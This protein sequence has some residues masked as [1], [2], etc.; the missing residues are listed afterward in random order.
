M[1]YVQLTIRMA[2]ELQGRIKKHA[3]A[4]QVSVNSFVMQTIEDALN[5]MPHENDSLTLLYSDPLKTLTRI[6]HKISDPWQLH[7]EEALSQDEL[8]FLIDGAKKQ[9]EKNDLLWPFYERV[10]EELTSADLHSNPEF[11]RTIFPFALK[12]YLQDDLSRNKFFSRQANLDIPTGNYSFDV[13]ESTFNFVISG[14]TW[15]K[16]PNSEHTAPPVLKLI[17]ATSRFERH[18]EWNVVIP[19]IRLMQ[20][21]DEGKLSQCSKGN[22]VCLSRTNGSLNRTDKD[23]FLNLDN[24]SFML[25]EEEL[26]EIARKTNALFKNELSGPFTELL[27]IYGEE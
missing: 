11:Q 7:K 10:R 3:K 2:Q 8:T 25:P 6:H 16:M 4:R 9:L 15:P 22:L 14:D 21:I 24:L 5:N 27:M 26:T 18:F 20:G 23:W 17:F 19:F 12:H 1:E 13:T